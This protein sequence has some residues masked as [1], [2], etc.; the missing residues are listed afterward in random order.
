M[1]GKKL[2]LPT[3]LTSEVC[4]HSSPDDLWMVVYNK[5]YD[6]T[7]FAPMHPGGAEVLL[8]C[9][10]VDGTEAFEDVGHSQDAFDMLL[11]YLVGQLPVEECKKYAHEM[12]LHEKPPVKKKERAKTS[13]DHHWRHVRVG[14]LVF[15]AV[16]A[17]VVVVALQRIQWLKLTS[18]YG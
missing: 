14:L 4:K 13:N 6:I 10:G 5:V 7:E 12:I 8:D 9:G 17:L 11:P 1:S 16:V 3:I 2:P 15:L 18:Y